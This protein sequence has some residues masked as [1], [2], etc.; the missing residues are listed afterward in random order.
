LL[1]PRRVGRCAGFHAKAPDCLDCGRGLFAGGLKERFDQVSVVRV[2]HWVKTTD[3]DVRSTS[4]SFV[5]VPRFTTCSCWRGEGAG[6]DFKVRSSASILSSLAA[7]F[8]TRGREDAVRLLSEASPFA[9]WEGP[10]KAPW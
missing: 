3:D 7:V 8:E 1:G 9:A 10:L 2:G 4:L 6:A 5:R